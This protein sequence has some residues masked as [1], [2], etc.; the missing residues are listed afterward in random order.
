MGI[1]KI[2]YKPTQSIARESLEIIRKE[3]EALN[4]LYEKMYKGAAEE[5]IEHKPVAPIPSADTLKAVFIPK[6]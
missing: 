5:I 2:G 6:K 1:G 3:Q 4:K